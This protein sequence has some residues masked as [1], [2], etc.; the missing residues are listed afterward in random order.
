MQIIVSLVP[1]LA[2]LI[3]LYYLDNYKLL[4]FGVIIK[5]IGFGAIA[6]LICLGL[7]S[8]ILMS[9]SNKLTTLYIAPIIE[10]SAKALIP[11]VLIRKRRI[12]FLVDGA[13]I[14]FAVGSGF[15]LIEN[16]YYLY[17]IADNRILLWIFR[18][19]GTA[20]MH[21]G[22]T[23]IFTIISVYLIGLKDTVK[24]S[25]FLPGLLVAI[26]I[27]SLYNH[28]ILPPLLN[29]LT[30]VIILPIIMLAVFSYRESAMSKWLQS[31]LDSDVKTLEFL[32]SGDFARSKQGRYIAGLRSVFT[33]EV[34]LD[35]LCY[36]RL[37]LELSIRAKGL[38][39]IR[40]T[41]MNIEVDN[42][43]KERF[44]ELAYLEQSIGKSGKAVLKPFLAKSQRELWQIYFLDTQQ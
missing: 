40:E 9:M 7:N 13:I 28:F 19:F 41:G 33:G 32:K 38:L 34:V 44:E 16:L 6:A 3:M 5:V 10:E 18:G 15:A 23:A 11:L 37:Y 12:G 35:I 21:G 36:L 26:I 4:T 29:T 25:Y 1:V 17:H 42:D 24:L 31:G 43:I 27:H 22:N 14:G 30:Q 2:F 20:I 39:M 8:L